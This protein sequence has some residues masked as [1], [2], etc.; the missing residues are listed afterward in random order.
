MARA[1]IDAPAPLSV[2]TPPGVSDSRSRGE[3]PPSAARSPFAPAPPVASPPVPQPGQQ[4]KLLDRLRGA[5]RARHY[6]R[7]T[8]Q[9]YCHWVKRFIFFHNVR[10]PG[11]MGEPE[12]NAFLTYL[13][14]KK[15]VSASTQNQALSALLF[16]YRHVLNRPLG[17]LGEVIRARKTKRLP[18]VLTRQEVRAVLERL[19]GDRWLMASLM[20]GAGLRLSEC[21][22]LRVQDVDL[23]ACQILVRD[24]KGFKDRLT[25][26]PEAVKARLVDHLEQVKR[27]HARDVADGHG[28]VNL[29]GAL[30]RKYPKAAWEWK[31]Q[32]VFPQE[33]RWRNPK[34]GEQGRHH[35][36]ESL[37][38]R[39]VK[40]A[41]TAAGIA[42]HATCHTL[43]HSFATHLLA[44]GYDIRTIQELLGH[45]DVKTTMVYT[46][47]LNRGGRGVRSPV[48]SLDTAA[49]VGVLCGNRIT[50][51]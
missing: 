42:K 19:E 10:H 50:P 2:E 28:R 14:T 22:R 44:A 37:I 51:Q 5:L 20:Y 29:P 38:Q 48:D 43:R 8:E 46:H 26:L 49:P 18:V 39:A 47:V 6:S 34:T 11:E 9:T 35:M 33:N 41:V 12:V 27:L 3:I 15:Q 40:V 16:L 1:G 17:K 36:D 25:V 13:A 45:K 23:E 4:P 31:W 32:Y 21:L 24:G 7:R 30:D